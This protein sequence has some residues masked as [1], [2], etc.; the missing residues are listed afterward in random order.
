MSKRA[1]IA[2]VLAVVVLMIYQYFL[3]PPPPP[4]VQ[5]AK[6]G[7]VRE[8]KKEVR[9]E[10]TKQQPTTQPDVTITQSGAEEK[11]I[12]IDTPLYEALLSTKGVTFKGWKLKTYLDENG[13]R[14]NLIRENVRIPAL[15]MGKDDTFNLKDLVFQTDFSQEHITLGDRD[16]VTLNFY[17]K[18]SSSG[19]T[20]KR[21]LTFY[22]NDYRVDV[23]DVVKGF[24]YYWVSLGINSGVSGTG[25]YRGHVGPVVLKDVD[26]KEY[27]PNKIKAPI[28]IKKDLRWL[29]MEDKYFFSSIVP[30]EK[31]EAKIWKSDTGDLLLA[32]SLPEGQN[33]YIF[34]TGPKEHDRLKKVGVGLEHIVDFGFFSILARPLFWF[35]KLLYRLTHNYGWAIIILTIIT[36]LPFIPIINRGQKSMK[37]LQKLQP[38]MNEIRQKYKKDPQRMQKEMMEL[39]KKHKVNPMSGCL[40]MLVQIPVFFALYKVLLV[41]I[42][43]RGAPF[44]LWIKD[45]SD[46]DPY[47]ILPIIM[48]I[49]MFVQQK[50]TPA[51]T[52]TQQQK[53]MQYMPVIFTL[54][55]LNFPSGL[56]L[57]WLVSNLLGIAQQ[58]YVNKKTT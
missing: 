58:Y 27:K 24:P 17:F 6:K 28:Y 44:M 2:I 23:K 54:L 43:L 3:A 55:F 30:P 34:Y 15:S 49:T 48:G 57:Y 38:M 46:K 20:I 19:V 51:A 4:P 33:S 29:A 1:L 26:R 13:K 8:T 21:S 47:Y 11:I 5:Q 39:Y 31:G 10:K 7:T 25:G 56:V 52:D 35:L 32:V 50:M 36:R 12:K 14:V 42:E 41:A 9:E 53:I 37:K 16:R 40:P 18:D 45:L 22:G